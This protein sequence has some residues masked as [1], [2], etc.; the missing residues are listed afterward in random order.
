MT[1]QFRHQESSKED[2]NI[3]ATGGEQSNGMVLRMGYGQNFFLEMLME[4]LL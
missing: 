2:T 3:A 4:E 1:L